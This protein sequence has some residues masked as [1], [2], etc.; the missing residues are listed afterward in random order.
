[1]L[2]RIINSPFLNLISGL[3]LLVSAGYETVESFDH[4]TLGAHHGILFFSI[5]QIAKSIPEILHGLK[6]IDEAEETF[7]ER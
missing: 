2:Q 1:M 3:V 4:L 7:E 6:E 5:V